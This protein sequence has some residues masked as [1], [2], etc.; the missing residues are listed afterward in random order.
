MQ[1]AIDGPIGNDENP[2]LVVLGVV[3]SAVPDACVAEVGKPSVRALV[4]SL[5]GD[6]QPL[7]ALRGL[8]L[9]DQ[10]LPVGVGGGLEAGGF[11]AEGIGLNE[12]LLPAEKLQVR[13]CDRCSRGRV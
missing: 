6:D 2:R 9:S 11:D 8:L 4:R 1:R 7:K 13:L 5:A 12:N 10:R 3:S